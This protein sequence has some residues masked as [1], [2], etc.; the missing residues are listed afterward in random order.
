MN[1]VELTKKLISFR[2]LT[3]DDDG[4]LEF[5]ASYLFDFDAVRID[6]GGVKNLFIYKKFGDGPHL[7]FAGHIDVVPAGEGW[8]SEPF[9]AF[10]KDGTLYGRGASDMKSGL[11]AFLTAV[12]NTKNFE[13]TLSLLLTS[14]EEGDATHGTVEILK[15]LEDKNTLPDL[16]IVAEPTCET[17]FGDTI[18]VGRR[19][20]INGKLKI[21]GRGGHA[22]YPQKA[23]NPIS[24]SGLLVNAIAD[25][26]LDDGDD[27][28][29][30]SQ[31][32]ITDIR[33]GYQK[34]NVIPT[35][36][37]MM[38]NVRNSTST[39][40]DSVRTFVETAA[41][42]CSIENFELEISQGSIGFV[43][44]KTE[45]ASQS[46]ELLSKCI[47]EHT[48]ITPKLST[49][50][51]T[52]DARFVAAYGVDVMEFGPINAT[53]HAPNECVSIDEIEK[54]TAIFTDFIAQ[55]HT[56]KEKL[57]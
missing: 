50:G 46:I 19:G 36:V 27:F 16:C 41:K 51:G 52:S 39:N 24:L 6:A 56:L 28:F 8:V 18:K 30:P 26:H 33:G 40:M 11:A 31:L 12:K 43:A 17:E 42:E 10:T 9:E 44:K 55:F 47:S 3:P 35:E 25:K 45:F 20:S 38:F 4:A 48:G 23:I 13:G 1:A 37:T 15:Y 49:S 34:T 14:D 22:A 7:S 57:G 2:S 54:L 29:S 32:V 5:I 21:I 53:I